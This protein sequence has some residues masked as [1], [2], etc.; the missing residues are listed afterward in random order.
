MFRN[1]NDRGSSYTNNSSVASNSFDADINS[2]NAEIEDNISTQQKDFEIDETLFSEEELRAMEA[3]FE[4][5]DEFAEI[6]EVAGGE[7]FGDDEE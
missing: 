5:D 3:S 7:E 2:F 4:L 1:R 6:P